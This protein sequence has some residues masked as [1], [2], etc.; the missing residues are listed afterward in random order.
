MHTIKME[1][2]LVIDID[3]TRDVYPIFILVVS[4]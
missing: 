3:N 1:I 4:L 2:A